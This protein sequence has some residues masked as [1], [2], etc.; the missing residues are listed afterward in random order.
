MSDQMNPDAQI[1]MLEQ[2]VTELVGRNHRLANQ[3]V[4]YQSRVNDSMSAIIKNAK[5]EALRGAAFD[6]PAGLSRKGFYNW[7]RARADKLVT[8]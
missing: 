7:L 6:L 2:K 1:A 8:E 4:G 3:I 5:A